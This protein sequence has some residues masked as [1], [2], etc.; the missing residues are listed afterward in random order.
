MGE[1]MMNGLIKVVV[2]PVSPYRGAPM[3]KRFGTR[4]CGCP[5][6]QSIVTVIFTKP[7]EFLPPTDRNNVS[8]FNRNHSIHTV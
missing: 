5:L 7:K 3:R 1:S 8:T 2:D 6:N 4:I